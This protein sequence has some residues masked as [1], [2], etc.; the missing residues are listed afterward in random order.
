MHTF[1]YY[2]LVESCYWSNW[3]GLIELSLPWIQD[4]FFESQSCPCVNYIFTRSV[5]YSDK[6]LQHV[7]PSCSHPSFSDSH[8]QVLLSTR[9]WYSMSSV[10][11]FIY[12]HQ[13]S[14][15]RAV[16][17]SNLN[18]AIARIHSFRQNNL[19]CCDHLVQRA[20]DSSECWSYRYLEWHYS[21]RSLN[22]HVFG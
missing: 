9:L 22:W 16:P 3:E 7:S 20:L 15:Y 12:S 17:I 10:N 2:S 19:L 18:V 14:G 21:G 4:P 11:C 5:S 13:I 6:N 1:R 8:L